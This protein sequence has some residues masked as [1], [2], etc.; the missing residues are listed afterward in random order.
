MNALLSNGYVRDIQLFFMNLF[1]VK[2]HKN[3]F[4]SSGVVEWKRT[5][6]RSDFNGNYPDTPTSP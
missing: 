2:C 3:P 6:R 1:K 5:E 4:S